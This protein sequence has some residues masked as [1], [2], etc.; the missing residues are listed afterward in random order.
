MDKAV[1]MS[2]T[3]SQFS[4]CRFPPAAIPSEQPGACPWTHMSVEDVQHRDTLAMGFDHD[5]FISYTHI[6]DRPL[7]EGQQGWIATLAEALNIRLAQLLGEDPRIWRDKKLSGNDRFDQEIIEQLVHTAVLVAVLSPR[8]VRSEWCCK[9][10]KAFAEHAHKTGGLVLDNKSRVFKVVKTPVNQQP[11][12]IRNL[13]GYL[14]YTEEP[15]TKRVREFN[16][17]FGPD[18]ELEFWRTLDDL[19]QDIKKLLDMLRSGASAERT[20]ATVYLAETTSDL[21]AERE[22][23]RRDLEAHGHLVLPDHPLPHTGTEL[24][25]VIEG[26]LERAELSIHLVGAVYGMVPEAR[27][28]SLLE[29]QNALASRCSQAGRLTRLVWMPPGLQPQDERQQAFVDTLNNDPDLSIH[30]SVLETTLEELKTVIH[31][32][33]RRDKEPSRAPAQLKRMYLIFD[34]PDKEAVTP[35]DDYLYE[36]GF[37]VKRPL[38][39]GDETKRQADHEDKL[40]LA[41]ALL[42]YC[43]T[44]DEAWLSRMLLD[45][46][47]I[48]GVRRASAVL[49]AGA[50][51]E[52]KARYRTREV[53]DVIKAFDR[54]DPTSLQRFLDRIESTGGGSR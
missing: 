8:Y 50:E 47:R 14:F 18:R 22:Q 46:V 32:K 54:F 20:G 39:S 33:L 48:P 51:T 15:E 26:Y 31:D 6:D 4:I 41:D 17:V 3:P 49:L 23:V 19:A 34:E 12:E 29:I 11:D 38:F 27:D 9:E 44:A 30:D 25:Q 21:A 16:R 5:V 36:R 24:E 37:E 42:I 2:Y 7:S 40:R 43:G 52:F 28:R 45:L 1:R 10:L 13:L 53:D 35:V